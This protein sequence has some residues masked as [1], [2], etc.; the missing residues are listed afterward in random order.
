MSYRLEIADR[1]RHKGE[2]LGLWERNLTGVT[3]ERYVWLYETGPTHCW[4]IR[5]ADGKL[6]GA[7][8]L[9]ERRFR[10]GERTV[11]AGQAIDLNIDRAHRSIGPA[12]QLQRATVALAQE[13]KWD[14]LYGLPNPQARPVLQRIGYRSIGALQRF[15]KPLRVGPKLRS[16][17]KVGQLLQTPAAAILNTA[18]RV[19]TPEAYSRLP[20]GLGTEIV[21]RFDARFDDLWHR[22]AGRF[23][24]IG[25]RTSDYLNWR[26]A[27]CPLAAYETFCLLDGDTLLGYVAFCI[28]EETVHIGDLLFE[29][30]AHLKL[31]LS[32]FLRT[33]RRRDAHTVVMKWFGAD[34]VAQQ[35]RQL[36]F[37]DRPQEWQMMIHQPPG[38]D[39]ADADLLRAN[40]WYLTRCDLD[41]DL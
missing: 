37:W 28:A 30:P 6:V 14:L 38:H 5:D 27:D 29:Q 9:A 24:V 16:R 41:S 25:E 26:F 12:L 39:T 36:G 1:P 10:V 8:G 22:T 4:A 3:A 2:I 20:S 34:L 33:V 15:V 23:G 32:E 11:Q 13:R 19:T 31:L 7:N 21:E 35:F 40:N 18:L 17:L